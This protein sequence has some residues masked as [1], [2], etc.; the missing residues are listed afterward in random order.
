MSAEP[1]LA[2]H[3]DVTRIHREGLQVAERV[4]PAICELMTELARAKGIRLQEPLA[5]VLRRDP[6]GR[7]HRYA[8]WA[9]SRERG[10]FLAKVELRS[11]EEFAHLYLR[12]LL[13]SRFWEREAKSLGETLCQATGMNVSVERAQ[14]DGII[15]YSESFSPEQF[16]TEAA[17]P[18]PA[19]AQPTQ[20]DFAISAVRVQTLAPFHFFHLSQETTHAQV[21]ND[22]A[23]L[24]QKL[25]VARDAAQ[26]RS[27]GGMIVRTIGSAERPELLLL[28][29]GLS[30]PPDTTPVGEA[31]VKAL[32][33][34][35]CVS[36]LYSGARQ[37]IDKTYAL[38]TEHMQQASLT[39]THERREAY[40]YYEGDDSPNNVIHV[41]FG[42][43]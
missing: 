3:D 36:V 40:L 23:A 29:V 9:L 25:I 1:G 21:V 28:E 2:T 35:R 27:D 17:Q 19:A 30:V 14:S 26:V 20:P 4:G 10:A 34:F 5:G 31:Q 32:L 41:M 38:L 39:P 8:E 13:Q 16:R 15:N 7:D 11:D 22:L 33:P 6:V 43:K 37:Y 18:A 12:A 42:I 24:R